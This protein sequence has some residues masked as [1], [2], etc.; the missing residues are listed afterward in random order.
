V[1]I[2]PSCVPL[3]WVVLLHLTLPMSLLA[4]ALPL[5][6]PL[7]GRCFATESVRAHFLADA[8][9]PWLL[10]SL[11]DALPPWFIGGCFAAIVARFTGGCFAVVVAWFIGGCFAA[12]AP[13]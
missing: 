13:G 1:P 6:A 11:A 5:L 9:P 12:I 3:L 7:S 2:M 4:D 8:L 10:G